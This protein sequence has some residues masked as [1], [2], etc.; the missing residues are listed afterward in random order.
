MLTHFALLVLFSISFQNGGPPVDGGTDTTLARLGLELS[1]DEVVD[2]QLAGQL[3][4]FLD[5]EGER[6][7]KVMQNYNQRSND[8]LDVAVK[9]VKSSVK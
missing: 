4:Q 7:S 2:P 3:L 6:D 5:N 9:V 8:R 1:D